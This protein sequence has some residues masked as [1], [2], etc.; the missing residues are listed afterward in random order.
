MTSSLTENNIRSWVIMVVRVHNCVNHL[1]F[2][3]HVSIKDPDHIS[4]P[5]YLH[6]IRKS[7][8]SLWA[9]RKFR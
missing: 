3:L 8:Y 9:K 7:R 1:A 2:A 6:L 5:T 4:S